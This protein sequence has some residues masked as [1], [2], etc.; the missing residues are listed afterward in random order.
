MTV[1]KIVIIPASGIGARMNVELP[2]QYLK[3]SNDKTILDNT[4]AVFAHATWAD[5][6]VVAISINDKWF[7]RSEYAKHPKVLQCWGG[8]TRAHSVYNA[9]LELGSIASAAD[10][11]FVHDAARPCVLLSDVEHLDAYLDDQDIPVGLLATPA[12]ETVKE[13]NIYQQVIKT[14][15]RQYIWLAQTPQV[16]PYEMLKLAYAKCFEDGFEVTDDASALEYNGLLPHLV[17]GKRSNIKITVED[18]LAFANYYLS[19]R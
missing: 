15:P 14:L 5:H 19:E 6:I 1:K 17:E 11:I 3:L 12:F 10:R 13:A 2:K 7:A 8:Q 9:L 16:A 4:I 18:D